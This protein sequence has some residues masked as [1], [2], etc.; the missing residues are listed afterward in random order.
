MKSIMKIST[1]ILM[2]LNACY[3]GELSY[4]LTASD[5]NFLSANSF[6]FDIYM[7]NT[8]RD[9]DIIYF[10]GQYVLQYNPALSNNGSLTCSIVKSDLPE[11]MRPSQS[12]FSEN[13]IRFS[14]NQVNMDSNILPHI[15]SV[16]PG[17][18]IARIVIKTSA[19]KFPDV[20]LNLTWRSEMPSTKI[21]ALVNGKAIEITRYE[22]HITNFD[23]TTN[24][25]F[26]NLL[27]LPEEFLL[28]Q[29]YPNPF[30]P[31]TNIK[32]NLPEEALV[33]IKIFDISGRQISTLIN[34]R[35]EAGR[36][37]VIFNGRNFASGVYFY[38]IEAG[39]FVNTN[40][41]VLIK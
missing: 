37:N 41:M 19:D 9:N 7:L 6:Q 11:T 2:L 8:S 5:I 3:A 12:I 23:N 25:S 26:Q 35:M 32:F 10:L 13:Q 33:K 22:N 28:E 21:A 27:Q 16:E 31:E 29:N 15:S 18:L 38:R 1:G 17:T 30:N 39:T 34:N 24:A 14:V 36:Y 4:R 20:P 40:R